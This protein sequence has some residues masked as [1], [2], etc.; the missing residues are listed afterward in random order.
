MSLM[1]P[2]R[3]RSLCGVR[4]RPRRRSSPCRRRRSPQ[5]R[6]RPRRRRR[7]SRRR[8]RRAP[9]ATRH[10]RR[11]PP[12]PGVGGRAPT[13][14]RR[15]YPRPDAYIN[16]TLYYD[17]EPGRLYTIETSP[18]FLTAIILRPGEKLIAKAAG[19]TVRWVLGETAEGVGA[20]QQVVVLVKP[21]R[22]GLRTNIVLTTDQRTYL[23]EAGQPRGRRLHQRGQLELSAGADAGA[24]GGQAAADAASRGRARPGDRSAALRLQDRAGPQQAAP[25]AADPRLRRRPEDLHPVPGQHG[26]DRRPA[27]VPGRPG[28][29]GRSWSTTATSTA[30]M[31]WTGCSTSPSCALARSRRWSCA[32]P[33]PRARAR[34]MTYLPPDPPMDGAAPLGQGRARERAGRAA[35]AGDALEPALSAAGRRRAW[36]PWSPPASTSASAA[37]TRPPAKGAAAAGRRRHAIV[38]RHLRPLRQGL[39]RSRRP[40]AT[41]AGR[42]QSAA[43]RR[44]AAPRRRRAA[45]AAAAGR[46]GGA[47]G[48]RPGAGRPVRE[49]VL[50]GRADRRG[51]RRRR[52]LQSRPHRPAPAPRQPGAGGR[53]AAGQR[54]GRQAPVPGRRR[55]RTTI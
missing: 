27:A 13:P 49:P 35:P 45:G 55:A 40:G 30:T 1:R 34:P 44:R 39:R 15:S 29:H 21:I 11:R 46:P 28:R 14:A 23:I 4:T 52:R 5:R 24:R 38:A 19:D 37:P 50:R 3:R 16:A 53:R 51:R 12:L 22:G 25:L 32:S 20:N 42:G 8:R 6:A 18:H 2:S 48:A 43:A 41:P 17:Y 54:P 33:A 9:S 36:P 47:A 10:H 31:W 7:G 26:L